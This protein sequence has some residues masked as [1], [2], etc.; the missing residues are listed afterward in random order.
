MPEYLGNSG[1]IHLV[2]ERYVEQSLTNSCDF[3]SFLPFIFYSLPYCK[4]FNASVLKSRMHCEKKFF[5]CNSTIYY[6]YLWVLTHTCK[7]SFFHL[8][9]ATISGNIKD[10]KT[11]YESF[12]KD[13]HICSKNLIHTLYEGP[14]NNRKYTVSIN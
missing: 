9:I 6:V 13:F 11:L 3:F 5:C 8:I 14:Q 4:L 7:H 10:F 12:K 1:T 2:P